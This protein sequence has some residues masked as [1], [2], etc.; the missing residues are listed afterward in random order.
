MTADRGASTATSLAELV[1]VLSQRLQAGEPLDLTAVIRAHL[2]HAEELRRLLPALG[3]L[4]DLAPA[5]DGRPPAAPALDLLGDFRILREV[6]RGGM[7]VVY[8]AEQVSLRRRV[9]LKVLPFAATLDPRQLQ[10]FRHEAQAAALLQH[11]NIVPVHAVGCERGVH[12]YAMQFIEGRTLAEAVRELRAGPPTRFAAPAASTAHGLGSALT[13]RPVAS[14]EHCRAAAR[15]AVQA[16]EALEYAHQVGVV[17]RDVKPANLLLDARGELWVTDFGL[18]LVRGHPELTVTGDLLGTLRYMSPEQAQAKPGVV[19]HRTDVYSLGAT[20]YELLTLEPAVPGDDRAAV[21]HRIAHAD[22]VPPRRH[23]P[24]VPTDLETVVLK[25]MARSRDERYATAREFADDLR[26]FLAGGPVRAKRVTRLQRAGKWAGRHRRLIATLAAAAV[27]AAVGVVLGSLDYARHQRAQAA[28]DNKR[29]QAAVRAERAATFRLQQASLRIARATRLARQ[30]GYLR[31][32]FAELT[33]AVGPPD[34]TGVEDEIERRRCVHA[35]QLH[36]AEVRREL[37]AGLGDPLGSE[38]RRFTPGRDWGAAWDT[39]SST[40]AVTP[41][42]RWAAKWDPAAGEVKLRDSGQPATQAPCPLGPVLDLKVSADGRLLVAGCE[43]GFAVWDLPGLTPRTTSRGGPVRFVAIDPGGRRIATLGDR[44][45]LWSALSNRRLA[46]Y[47]P[48]GQF[49]TAVGFSPD[50][51]YLLAR[52]DQSAAWPLRDTPEKFHLDGHDGGVLAVAF[53]PDGRRLASAARDRTVRLWD[54]DGRKPVRTWPPAGPAVG[55]LAFSPDGQLL[56]VGDADGGVRLLDAA[57]GAEAA[58][59]RVAGGL[60]LRLQFT[61][62]GRTLLAAAGPAGLAAWVLPR[63]EPVAVAKLPE[64]A[65]GA[66][67]LAVHPGGEAM[68]YITWNGELYRRPLRGGP[69][70]RLL[71]GCFGGVRSLGFDAAGERL[72]FLYGDGLAVLDWRTGAGVKSVPARQATHSPDGRWAAI[73]TDGRAVRVCDRPT[74]AVVFTLPPED[75]EVNGLAWAPG[76]RLLAVGLADGDVAVWD[77]DRVYAR[78]AA[79]GVEPG[80]DPEAEG[81]RFRV[82]PPPSEP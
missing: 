23:N 32:Y 24:A 47:P 58:R 70:R 81:G 14:A 3:A 18:A 25:A 75:A 8:E 51:K 41:D 59:G 38:P 66:A 57:T 76:R 65:Q 78:F 44:V 22:P 12:Y 69:D 6:G 33:R 72:T 21:L 71:A 46:E 42:G 1:D 28:E 49:P 74:G 35:Y 61:P 48:P 34:L 60:I 13:P 7:G 67:D 56:A 27:V 40:A 64:G 55:A 82:A 26:R 36:L 15:L 19:D 73:T 29:M 45:E 5:G 43:Q 4:D 80:E 52:G 39:Q 20:L 62:D 17:H 79:L 10:R 50:G 68:A 30:P 77:L 11:P 31:T 54:A 53:T 2:E 37:L 9:A 16:A 63:L